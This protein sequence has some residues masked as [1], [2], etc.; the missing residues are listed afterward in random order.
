MTFENKEQVAWDVIRGFDKAMGT[1]HTIFILCNDFYYSSIS[2]LI[3][4]WL[5][6]YV[7]LYVD[8]NNAMRMIQKPALKQLYFS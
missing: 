6:L 1:S 5:Q 4:V 3:S 2:S 8:M 7:F